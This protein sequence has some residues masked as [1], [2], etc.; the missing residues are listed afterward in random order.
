MGTMNDDITEA[1]K[2]MSQLA[3]TLRSPVAYVMHRDTL[4][5]IEQHVGR[6]KRAP[7]PRLLDAGVH[8]FDEVPKGEAI[9]FFNGR[10]FAWY[11]VLRRQAGH[12]AA[13]QRIAAGVDPSLIRVAELRVGLQ[14]N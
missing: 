4:H 5:A 6:A 11:L 13:L 14:R 9:V 2:A 10:V 7:H 1:L 8:C 12:A 3:R